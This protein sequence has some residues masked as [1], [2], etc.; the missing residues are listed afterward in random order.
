ML[1]C[2]SNSVLCSTHRTLSILNPSIIIKRAYHK[3]THTIY[4][5]FHRSAPPVALDIYTLTHLSSF[6]DAPCSN[7]FT[8]ASKTCHQAVLDGRKQLIDTLREHIDP[9]LI[10]Q[11]FPSCSR[12]AYLQI[13]SRT[14][15][16]LNS[17]P[18]DLRPNFVDTH[19]LLQRPF[20]FKQLL[21]T[22]LAV[23]RITIA[24]ALGA[25]P[26]AVA[27]N[28]WSQE[29]RAIQTIKNSTRTMYLKLSWNNLTVLPPEIGELSHLHNL[30]L[31]GNNLSILPKEIGKCVL[32]ERLS[33]DNNT[34]TTLPPEIN[35]CRHLQRL[36]LDNNKLTIL[37]S[38]CAIPSLEILSVHR[39]RL[40]TIAPEIGLLSK[41]QELNLNHNCLRHLPHTIGALSALQ[42]LSLNDNDLV[43]L[44]HEFQQ[45]SAVHFLSLDIKTVRSKN[46]PSHLTQRE[47]KESL[48]I[49]RC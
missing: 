48:I 20:A 25:P 1:S 18:E 39:N 42:S 9:E 7:S 36:Y 40:H 15:E 38:Q 8:L 41:L 29:E 43:D 28:L 31:R 23:A 12:D 13:R 34:L 5:L 21:L 44:P 16:L 49:L 14:Q 37:P 6:L 46:I 26:R 30:F 35:N 3:L 17:L 4:R 11:F 47:N 45:L 24:H 19:S 33:L 22:H 27:D 32:L 2:L 10:S